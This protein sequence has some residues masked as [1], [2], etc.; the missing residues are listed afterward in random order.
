[1]RSTSDFPRLPPSGQ[2]AILNGPAATPPEGVSPD[3]ADP[4]NGNREALAVIVLCFVL[5]TLEL[6]GRVYSRVFLVKKLHIEDCASSVY[7]NPAK[8]FDRIS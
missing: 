8:S 5:S 1:M 4:T 6:L 2:Q 3:F 7:T